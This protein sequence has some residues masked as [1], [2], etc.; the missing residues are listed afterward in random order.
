M[1]PTPPAPACSFASDNAAGAHPQ[2]MEA[3]VEANR[4][5]SLAYG[6][7]PWTAAAVDELRD[8]FE[9]PVEVLFC[10]GG[11]GAN[12]VGLASVV[13]PWQAVLCVD[14]A[15]IVVDEAGGPARFTGAT[16]STVAHHDG[17]LDPD[18]IDEFAAWRGVVHHPQPAAVS[19]SQVTEQGSVYRTD[20]LAALA[21]RC[22][23]HGLVLHLDGAR[24]ANAV[25]ATGSTLRE[26]CVDTG[27]DLLTFGLTKNGAMYGEAVVF[28]RPELAA[29]AR[30]VHK[31]AGQLTSKT[32]F[33]AAQ[34][35][36]L[37][38]DD[39]WLRSAAHANA[40]ATRLA[41]S[42]AAV[43][44]VAVPRPP[45]ANA[46]LATIP[47]DRLDVLQDWSFFWPWDPPTRTVRWMTGWATTAADVD[48]FADGVRSILNV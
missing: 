37:L 1:P 20:E 41:D 24:L 13:Q 12:I 17:K 28:L 47:W 4:G 48:R 6:E 21:E 29:H 27:V 34:C 39:L 22:R 35:S 26:M 9:A 45:E 40:M 10:W 25:V 11:T 33:V 8:R 7:D 43:P 14:T 19:V 42:V 38:R 46:V 30:F 32:R 23:A 2:V 16:V 3:L 18:R 15:H 5:P 31:Q 36:A 44:G